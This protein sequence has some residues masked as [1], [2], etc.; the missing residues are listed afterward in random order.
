[1]DFSPDKL[2][3]HFK[4]LTAQREKIDAKLEPLHAELNSL[5]AGDTDL[6]VK[7]AHAREAV[8]RTKIK[9]LQAERYPLEMERAAVAR[10]L[11]GKTGDA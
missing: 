7:K 2:R 5:V 9:E 11:G 8:I 10:A 4:T 1:M 6:S 3:A